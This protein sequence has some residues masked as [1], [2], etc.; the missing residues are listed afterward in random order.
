MLAALAGF[1]GCDS[2]TAPARTDAEPAISDSA[3]VRIISNGAVPASQEGWQIDPA[4]YLVIGASESR[5]EEYLFGGVAG[6][7]RLRH[8]SIVIA[9]WQAGDVR[10]FDS[11]G[12]FLRRLGRRGRGPGEFRGVSG[13]F[14]VGDTVIVRSMYDGDPLV[15]FHTDGGGGRFLTPSADGAGTPIVVDVWPDLSLLVRVPR[16][17]TPRL[18]APEPLVPS[19]LEFPAEFYRVGPDG[20]ILARF[21]EHPTERSVWYNNHPAPGYEVTR[22][23]YLGQPAFMAGPEG[24]IITEGSSFQVRF[25]NMDG[26]LTKVLRKSHDP[27]A[28][29]PRWADSLW[30]ITVQRLSDSEVGS[31]I[32]RVDP[33][34]V[35]DH[36]PALSDV[37]L[38]SEGNIWARAAAWPPDGPGVW[39]VFDSDG[40]LQHVLQSPVQPV[41]IGADFVLAIQ[42]DQLGVWSV[43]VHRLVK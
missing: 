16:F 35:P 27:P 9:D 3:G 10:V 5:S 41:Q 4:P 24:L 2:D 22:P 37:L 17:R 29:P 1:M 21:G 39:H 28:I 26:E 8:G 42:Q 31:W 6:A 30:A 14:V 38:D 15:L 43:A 36:M 18:E 13:L 7:A 12:T 11:S 23:P 34:P 19:V 20:Q 33:P 40:V 32:S 25:Y